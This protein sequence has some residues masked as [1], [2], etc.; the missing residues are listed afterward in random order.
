VIVVEGSFR[1]PVENL[2]QARDAMARVVAASRDEPG[3][4]AYAYAEDLLEPGLIRVSEAWV[5]GEVL[6]RH[7]EAPH[8]QQW[9][10][11]REAL[12][13]TDRAM[14]MHAVKNGVQI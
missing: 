12:G 5:S 9:K 4:L 3:C 11:E 13:M 14:T 6:A 1:L 2:A 10:E 8:M 7:L